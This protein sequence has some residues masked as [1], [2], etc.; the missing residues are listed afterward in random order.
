VVGRD[1]VAYGDEAAG[2]DDVLDGAGLPRHA[3]EVRRAAYVRRARIPREQL[4][5]GDGQLPPGRV[6][7]VHVRVRASEHL[8]A[9]RADDRV[10]DLRGRGP[11]VREVHVLAGL[12]LA[13]RLAGQVEVHPSGERVGDDQR[14]RREVIRLHLAVDPRLE[15]AIPGEH[16]AHHEVAL[17]DCA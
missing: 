5:L 4:A 11:Q 7:G 3:V 2:A 6:A 13:E 9:D 16:C 10:R 17:G 12:V 15:V 14:W 1:R 8:L